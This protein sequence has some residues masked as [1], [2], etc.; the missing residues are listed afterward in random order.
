MDSKYFSSP[1][2]YRIFSTAAW[3]GRGPSFNRSS[4][5][6]PEPEPGR[7]ERQGPC[8]LFFAFHD[9][10][11]SKESSVLRW[12]LSQ[13][14]VWSSW[15][16]AGL[17][18][19]PFVV[20]YIRRHVMPVCAQIGGNLVKLYLPVF[21][22]AILTFFLLK[23]IIHLW[24]ATLYRYFVPIKLLTNNFSIHWWFSPESIITKVVLKVIFSL[25]YFL[26]IYWLAFYSKEEKINK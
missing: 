26:C 10:D 19:T 13:F 24:G 22:S 3:A 8:L 9:L 14:S 18:T 15:S 2:A 5:S 11:V 16:Y 6:W 25:Y 23:L 20:F 21:S 17:C 12:H 4:R 7:N 1:S